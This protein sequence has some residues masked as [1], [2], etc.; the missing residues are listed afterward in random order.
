MLVFSAIT[1]HTPLLISGVGKEHTVKLTAT[2][3]ALKK[4]E[5][6]F[7][8][9]LPET[10]IIISPHGPANEKSFVLNFSPKYKG[11]FGEFGDLATKLTANGDNALSYKI[12]ENLETKTSLQLTTIEQLDYS[13]LAPLYFLCGHRKDIKIVPISSCG[14]SLEDHF[15]FGQAL[16]EKISAET[17]RV[18]VVVS[19]ETSTKLTKDSSNGYAVGA[20]KFDQKFIDLIKQKSCKEIMTV[21]EKQLEKMGCLEYKAMFVLFGIL[22]ENNCRPKLLSYEYPFG[23]GHLTME[24][25]I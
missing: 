9:S 15:K 11:N 7:Y 5:G 6:D 21:D 2:I 19:A 1:P 13:F 20:K 4:M 23:T 3:N 16:A 25:G 14:L 24:F 17:K 10:L 22:S 12:K 18:A 8:V